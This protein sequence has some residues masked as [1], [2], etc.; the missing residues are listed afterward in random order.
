[1]VVE[2]QGALGEPTLA[3]LCEYIEFARKMNWVADSSS[4]SRLRA[5]ERVFSIDPDWQQMSL[6]DLDLESYRRRYE[7]ATHKDGSDY[8]S[9]IN[10]TLKDYEVYRRTGK[11]PEKHRRASPKAKARPRA[12]AVQENGNGQQTLLYVDGIRVSADPG[13]TL[14]QERAEKLGK[15]LLL[16][17]T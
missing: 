10:G 13:T 4:A 3:G 2:S 7:R 12:E 9:R 15:M 1:M 11:E 8:I 16:L 17:V 6:D 5:V 14:T